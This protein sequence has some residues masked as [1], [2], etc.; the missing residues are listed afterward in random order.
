MAL[1]VPRSADLIAAVLGVLKTGAAYLP[2]DPDTPAGRVRTILEDAGPRVGHH[3]GVVGGEGRR[4][5]RGESSDDP[6]H[7]AYVIYTSGSTGKP[8]GVV[9]SHVGLSSLAATQIEGF[10]VRPGSRV[11]QF[12]SIGFDASVSEICMALLSGATLVV[13]TADERA[14]GEPLARFLRERRITHATIPPAALAVMSPDD[15][16]A[17]LAVIV[18]GEASNPDLVARWAAAHPM[19]NAYGP[20]ENTVDA[21]WCRLRPE[22][23]RVDRHALGQHSG[24]RARRA[25]EAGAT[26]GSG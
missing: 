23:R 2:I 11:L 19:F 21:T 17:D 12:A 7:P 3:P 8:K 18:A 9:V 20:T 25:A 5:V 26:R 6:R 16:P 22:G 4:G 24:V 10:G 14:P 13:P 15:V 1:A